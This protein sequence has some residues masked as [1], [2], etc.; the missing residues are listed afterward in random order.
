[1]KTPCL[2]PVKSMIFPW[3]ALT[4]LLLASCA[5]TASL[6]KTT[7]SNGSI[8]RSSVKQATKNGYTV[9]AISI[10][11]GGILPVYS[12]LTFIPGSPMLKH[13]PKT[14][15]AQA[16]NNLVSLTLYGNNVKFNKAGVEQ[17]FAKA[18]TSAFAAQS[19]ATWKN[20]S[21]RRYDIRLYYTPEK[22]GVSRQKRYLMLGRTFRLSF[23]NSLRYGLRPRATTNTLAHESYHLAVSRLGLKTPP[24]EKH[25][26]SPAQHQ[27]LDEVSA[28]AFGTCVVLR[29]QG[30]ALLKNNYAPDVPDGNGIVRHG[31]LSDAQMRHILRAAANFDL[32]IAYKYGPALFL[33]LWTNYAG[34][35]KAI[36]FGDPAADKFFDLCAHDIGNPEDIWPKLWALANDN[37]DAPEIAPV[38]ADA[39]S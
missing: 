5:A 2:M 3:I 22:T 33:T 24:K 31:T 34:Q 35:A 19:Q 32:N 16:S 10:G 12:T 25:D 13:D 36:H 23:Y 1:M 14:V 6:P 7:M 29:A 4:S 11:G 37:K 27:I 30:A 15:L 39:A 9:N 18:Y 8:S 17:D 38:D 21:K 20:A 26:L 28:A